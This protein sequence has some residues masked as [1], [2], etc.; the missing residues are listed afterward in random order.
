MKNWHEM[1]QKSG[2]YGAIIYFVF[3][4]TFILDFFYN[5]LYY[6]FKYFVRFASYSALVLT[7]V[8]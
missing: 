4:I 5:L 2:F 1:S 8:C 6:L 3:I 7:E